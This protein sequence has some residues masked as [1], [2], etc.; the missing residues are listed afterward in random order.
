MIPFAGLQKEAQAPDL[1]RAQPPWNRLALLTEILVT[2]LRD[3]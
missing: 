3:N 1:G 2:V